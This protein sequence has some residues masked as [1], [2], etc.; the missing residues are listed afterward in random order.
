M[1]DIEITVSYEELANLILENFG[2]E[3]PPGNRTE[4]RVIK[5]RDCPSK[6]WDDHIVISLN[7][8]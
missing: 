3:L 5:V 1:D 2:G 8:V 6:F 4:L 7:E